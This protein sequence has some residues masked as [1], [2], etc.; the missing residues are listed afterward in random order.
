MYKNT[1]RN[2]PDRK[3][4]TP[5]DSEYRLHTYFQQ[6]SHSLAYYATSILELSAIRYDQLHPYLL[7]QE[8]KNT[9]VLFDLPKLG[10]LLVRFSID[11]CFC[12]WIN[13]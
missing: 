8:L 5:L 1:H 2:N 12:L 4:L 3:I 13:V 6:L 10:S 9:L 7:Q 11:L